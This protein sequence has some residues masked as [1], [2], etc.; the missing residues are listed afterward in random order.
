MSSTGNILCTYLN[1]IIGANI[2][3]VRSKANAEKRERSGLTSHFMFGRGDADSDALAITWV[4]VEVGA[5]Q[6][7]HNHPEV[8]VYIIVAGTGQMH[9]GDETQVVQA[10]DLIFIPSEAFHGIDNTGDSVLSYVS[11]A[12]P[13]FESLPFAYDNGQLTPEAYKKE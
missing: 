6:R 1:S 11:A 9:V 13:A 4:D 5:K 2:M 3:F 12:S 10:G 7:L 8:Q